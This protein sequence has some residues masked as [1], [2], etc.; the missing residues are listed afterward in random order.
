MVGLIGTT[1]VWY[2]DIEHGFNRSRYTSHGQLD[3]YG[4][5]QDQLEWTIQ[6]IIDTIEKAENGK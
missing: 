6:H 4:C 2:N 1:A 5:N 3:E